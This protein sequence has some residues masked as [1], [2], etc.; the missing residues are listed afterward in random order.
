MSLINDGINWIKTNDEGIPVTKV[1]EELTWVN[2]P[3]AAEFGRGQAW[4]SDI[5]AAGN[6]DGNSWH[7][8]ADKHASNIQSSLSGVKST[9]SGTETSTARGATFNGW[10]YTYLRNNLTQFDTVTIKEIKRAAGLSGT[11]LWATI[12]V[13]VVD[14]SDESTA[15]K[16]WSDGALLASAVIAVDS[17][18]DILSNLVFNLLDPTGRAIVL[19]STNLPTRFGIRYSAYN[20]GGTN[21]VCGDN[22]AANQTQDTVGVLN[23]SVPARTL[24][25]TATAGFYKINGVWQQVNSATYKALDLTLSL[26]TDTLP[27]TILEPYG[28]YN[29]TSFKARLAR[30]LD[31]QTIVANIGVIGDS[32]ANIQYIIGRPIARKLKTLYGDAGPGYV[33]FPTAYTAGPATGNVDDAVA[34]IARTGTWVTDNTS[35][36]KGV[37]G[38]SISSST[39]G[40][41]I[42]ITLIGTA[43]R[44]V[45]HYYAQA[46]GGAVRWKV[47]A[48]AWTTISTVG[49]ARMATA[50][51]DFGADITG[52][53]VTIEVETAGTSGVIL[54]GVDLKKD[55]AGVRV[56]KLGHSG[57]YAS[58]IT[59]ID[60]NIGYVQL[61]ALALDLAVIVFTTNEMTNG[62]TP[63][64]MVDNIKTIIRRIKE[65]RPYCDIVLV[66]PSDNATESNTYKHSEYEQA[67]YQL[68]R[69]LRIGFFP[70]KTV[71]GVHGDYFHNALVADTVPHPNSAGGE[72]LGRTLAKELLE[73]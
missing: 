24:N 68:A 36:A 69:D 55:T 66:S 34:T 18:V 25:A 16:Y 49:T 47:D 50:E 19:N 35:S 39:V 59:A 3:T 13:E 67:M 40:D 37:D 62:I 4:F 56:H 6:S 73:L 30:I 8:D 27:I 52:V 38:F 23:R 22:R 12:K 60:E 26:S 11:D 32:W 71:I 57:G 64:V 15:A 7:I 58:T 65:C 51:I 2:K 28:K 31:S 33:G 61:A 29:L 5:E 45:L 14:M 46:A 53:V 43:R 72:L 63:S 41:S 54:H 44:A 9:F 1:L 48:G 70:C 10:G 17:A 21:A 42:A 20:G